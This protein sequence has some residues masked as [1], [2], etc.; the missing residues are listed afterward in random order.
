MGLG[1]RV[2]CVEWVEMDILVGTQMMMIMMTT[3]AIRIQK[4]TKAIDTIDNSQWSALIK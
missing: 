2:I 3:I 1:K 4:E